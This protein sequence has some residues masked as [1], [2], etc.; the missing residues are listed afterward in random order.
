MKHYTQQLVLNAPIA[1]LYAALTTLEGLRAWWTQ[2]CD[3]EAELG[4]TLHFRFG[5]CYKDMQIERQVP[6]QE[7][8]WRCTVAHIG[9]EGLARKDEWVGTQVIFRL[10][11]V[12]EG[13]TR[14]DFEHIG[15]VPTF[16]CYDLC[17]DGWR[18]FMGSLQKL[19]E[20]GH[21]TPYE[22]AGAAA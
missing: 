11:P 3:G 22:L 10:T 12:A 13:A 17:S 6:I 18:H 14:L 15:L 1:T 4:G 2:D 21:G 8:R 7:V 20:T 9:V 16:E 5:N 19:V